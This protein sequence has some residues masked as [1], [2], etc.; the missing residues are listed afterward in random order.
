MIKLKNTGSVALY[1][2]LAV[3]FIINLLVV[4]II[5]IWMKQE[6]WFSPRNAQK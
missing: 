3:F 2:V 5:F 4:L 6:M 1:A